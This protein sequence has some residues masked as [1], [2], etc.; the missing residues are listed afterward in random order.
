LKRIVG[1]I[2]RCLLDPI[3]A[4]DDAARIEAVGEVQGRAFAKD[5]PAE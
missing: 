5:N 1:Q 4:E 2:E 3:G